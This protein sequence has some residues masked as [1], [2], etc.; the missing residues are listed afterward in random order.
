[1]DRNSHLTG[2]VSCRGFGEVRIGGYRNINRAVDGDLVAVRLISESREIDDEI[3]FADDE[4]KEQEE[5]VTE[6]MCEGEKRKSDVA[7][8]PRSKSKKRRDSP[9]GL[10]LTSTRQGQV[11]GIIKRNWKEYSGT[12]MPTSDGKI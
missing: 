10:D 5:E 1:M 3:F 7:M 6:K 12:L 9:D 4:E 2:T 11:V 8:T